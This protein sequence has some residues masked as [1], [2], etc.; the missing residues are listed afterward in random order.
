M[1]SWLTPGL[2]E[3]LV[4]L[5]ALSGSAELSAREI[6]QKLNA[7]FGTQLSRNGIIGRAHRLELPIRHGISRPRKPRT[8]KPRTQKSRKPVAADAPILPAMAPISRNQPLT[9]YQLRDGDCRWPLAQVEDYPPFM[10]CGRPAPIGTPYCA[11]H[12]AR[13]YNR[14]QMRWE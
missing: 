6:A 13:S 14:P 11:E 1:T 10:Y 12:C 8:Q 9:I 5:Y 7:E 2:N 3:R 4:E